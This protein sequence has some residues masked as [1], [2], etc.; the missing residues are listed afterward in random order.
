MG[1]AKPKAP[2]IPPKPPLI[3]TSPATS[4]SR[5]RRR[6]AE[7][8]A[9]GA[10]D[11]AD[12]LRFDTAERNLLDDIREIFG[13][14]SSEIERHGTHSIYDSDDPDLI[15]RDGHAYKAGRLRARR[16]GIAA[17]KVILEGLIARVEERA[18]EADEQVPSPV[19]A[20]GAGMRPSGDLIGDWRVIKALRRDGQGEVFLVEREGA[21]GHAIGVL[22]RVPQ[23]VATDAKRLS[24]FKHEIDIVQKLRHP[25][26]AE[27]LDTNLVGETWF[28]TRFAPLGSLLDNVGWFKGD[29]WRTLRMGRDLG[30]ALLAAHEAKVIHRDVKPG[31][32]LLYDPNH[33]ALTDFGIAHHPDHTPVTSTHEKV[34]PRWFLPPEAEHGRTDPAPSHDV[35]MLGKVLYFTLTGGKSFPRERFSDS[36]ANIE[37]MFGRPELSVVNQLLGQMI[38]EEPSQRLQ[39]MENVIA[40]IDV[41]L[42][43]LFGRRRGEAE[44]RLVFMFGDQGDNRYSGNHPG[45][46]MVPVW[47]PPTTHLIVDLKIHPGV[48][49]AQFAV[50]FWS[51]KAKVIDSGR[52]QQGRNEVNVQPGVGGRWMTLHVRDDNNNWGSA[53][54]SNLVVHAA[55]GDD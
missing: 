43:K 27:M 33:V 25:F 49:D 10:I 19:L 4:I 5:L 8:E 3:S 44:H 37:T 31:N 45:L 11:E 12:D 42:A 20:G 46:Q 14:G 38:V 23:D 54:I 21:G 35:Y 13:E 34:G 17:T 9:L 7:V 39:T 2:T 52:L 26:I 36:E 29:V 48:N 6:I 30:A 40:G 16:R 18:S 53:N 55:C 51:D 15:M 22:K 41:A 32:V 1:V 28:V 24:R 47:M 50:E